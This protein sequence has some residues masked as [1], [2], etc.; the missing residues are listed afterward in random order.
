MIALY[1]LLLV[2]PWM[3]RS[4]GWAD[5][6]SIYAEHPPTQIAMGSWASCHAKDYPISQIPWDKYTHITYALL[7]TTPDIRLKQ[8]MADQR[9]LPELSF[10]A[11]RHVR[12]S[13]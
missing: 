5:I 6:S 7:E 8:S 1:S 2:L 10:A 3:V 4:W 11:R 12:L 13:C 9:L